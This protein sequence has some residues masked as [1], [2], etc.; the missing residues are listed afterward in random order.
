[1]GH[2]RETVCFVVITGIEFSHDIQQALCFTLTS[3]KTA[4]NVLHTIE[5]LVF[6]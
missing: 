5:V 3:Q 2:V 1:V 6:P 4:G